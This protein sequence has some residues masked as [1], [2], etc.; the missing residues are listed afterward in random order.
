MPC[1]VDLH[2]FHEKLGSELRT[3]LKNCCIR[4]A[5]SECPL[6]LMGFG[7]DRVVL[8]A[9]LHLFLLLFRRLVQK[10]ALSNIVGDLISTDTLIILSCI[11]LVLMLIYY[12]GSTTSLDTASSSCWIAKEVCQLLFLLK[13][14]L[15][16]LFFL[17]DALLLLSQVGSL[18][19]RLLLFALAFKSLIFYCQALLLFFNAF[20][21]LDGL[22][23]QL[24]LLSSLLPGHLL[25]LLHFLAHSPLQL[26]LA[27]FFLLLKSQCLLL[28]MPRL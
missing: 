23:F 26:S 13:S 16:C 17:L 18:L 7:Q 5:K 12:T 11:V 25:L 19:G 28:G 8:E 27:L 24:F 22:P 10:Q 21:F 1:C 2:G 20:F 14:A 6:D 9:L 15:S 4:E 3:R